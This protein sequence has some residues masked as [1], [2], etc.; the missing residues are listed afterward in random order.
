M[1][2]LN[3]AW[4]QR[5]RMPPKANLEQRIEWHLAHAR[6]CACREIPKTVLA[7]VRARGIRLPARR[8]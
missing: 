3:A 8:A 6:A 2:K 5:N 4:H 1:P 7:A